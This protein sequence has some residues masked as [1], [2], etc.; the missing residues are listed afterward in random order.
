MR[1]II[2]LS[3]CLL[4]ALS[5]I[6]TQSFCQ[7]SSGN[8][9]VTI[10][11]LTYETA[12]QQIV[13]IKRIIAEF[14][15]L[16]PNI[17]V[18]L[19]PNAEASRIFLVEMASG[20]PPDVMYLVG[21]FLAQLVAKN[22]VLDLT[23]FIEQD[24]IDMSIFY[25]QVRDVLTFN[26]KLYAYPIH[27]ST[28]VIFYNRKLFDQA[29]IPYPDETWTWDDYKAAATKLTKDTN[30][31]GKIDQFGTLIPDSRILIA[32]FGG[33]FFNADL[34]KC[35]INSPEARKAL[36]WGMSMYGKEAPTVAQ[37]SDTSDM[38]LFE[39]GRLGM[40]IGRTWQLVKLT[41]TM[42]PDE[43]DVAPM[44][45]GARR[46]SVLAV[47]GHCI[48][49]GSKHPKETWEFIKFYSSAEGQ[50]LLGV[51]K[52]CVPANIEVATDTNYFLCPPPRSIKLFIDSLS[53][54]IVDIPDTPWKTELLTRVWNPIFEKIRMNAMPIDTGLAELQE[55][56]NIFLSEFA[57][58]PVPDYGAF[59]TGSNKWSN[60]FPYGIAVAVILLVVLI[61]AARKYHWMEGYLF[62]AP[63]LLGF[64]IFIV[65]P[66][67]ASF[68]LSFTEYDILSS[69]HWVGLKNYKTLFT[70]PLFKK[71][72]FNT[73]YYVSFTVPLG[74]VFSLF[75]A[76]LLNNKIR[77]IY[78]FRVIYYLPAVTSGVAI[79]LLWR[80]LYN[81]DVGLINYVL[82]WFGIPAL[83][84]LTSPTWALPAI[85]IMAIWS[86]VGG[87]M[88]IYLAGLQG[89]PEHLYESAEI[90]GANF[91]HKFRYVTIPM[92]SPTIFFNLIIGII[93][94]FQVFTS[95]YVMTGTAGVIE[96]GGPANSTLVYILYL[97][98][99]AFRY[100]AM[101]NACAMAWILFLIILGL[102]ILNFKVA[103]HW[104]H[105]EQT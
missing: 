87:P 10:R 103:Q 64:L 54:S 47:G 15:K 35:T 42:N 41:E 72:L 59:Q 5:I 80:W 21:T 51:Q 66:I 55:K 105:Y 37:L 69:P 27:F 75:L 84:W 76:M 8:K 13:G 26:G 7:D 53:Y 74:L 89:I 6:T 95:V 50:K 18:Q 2:K 43:W 17:R 100:L 19:E 52:N 30:G 97:Y 92:L 36:A 11:Y 99:N 86:F 77:G 78:I 34:T 22:A 23:P 33:T 28:N 4:F 3:Y 45:K 40:F 98:Q 46:I 94:S 9:P 61:I 44:P 93:N 58:R 96:P 1:K 16:H 65:G 48:T 62:I 85:I 31:D 104:V 32:S 24:Q 73:V 79:S 102:T 25:P 20:T 101:G 91:W 68:L 29:G 63:W 56:T 14:E 83:G 90:D 81:P 38:Q 57:K 12:H 70:D 71:S 39:N 49:R 82:S 67:I 60:Y 88:I